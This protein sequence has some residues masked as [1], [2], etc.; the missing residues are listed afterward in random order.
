MEHLTLGQWSQQF[1]QS[2]RQA[3]AIGVA[4]HHIVIFALDKT[5]KDTGTERVLKASNGLGG[6]SVHSQRLSTTR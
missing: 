2:F 3:F 1:L 5:I 6:K 4:Q